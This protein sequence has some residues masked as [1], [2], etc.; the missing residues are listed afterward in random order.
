MKE[1]WDFDEHKNYIDINIHGRDYKV[2]KKFNLSEKKKYDDQFHTK[3]QKAKKQ[4]NK[5][6]L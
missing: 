6:N 2:I 4:P 3:I 5:Y 1:F